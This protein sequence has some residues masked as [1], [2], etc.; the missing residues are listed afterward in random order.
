MI[1]PFQEAIQSESE[2]KN[3]ADV[4]LLR[5]ALGIAGDDAPATLALDFAVNT[6]S[7]MVENYVNQGLTERTVRFWYQTFRDSVVL[8]PVKPIHSYKVFNAE[9]NESLDLGTL[10]KGGLLH[11]QNPPRSIFIE[12]DT[13]YNGVG[14]PLF[15]VPTDIQ[16]A[17]IEIARTIYIATVKEYGSSK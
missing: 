5:D 12:V 4:V 17:V 10:M 11:L 3:L 13:G 1:R 2:H 7:R 15:D 8:I 16:E 14:D 6:A 9:T